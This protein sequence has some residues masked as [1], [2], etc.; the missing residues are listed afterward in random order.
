[1]ND[2]LRHIFDE[3]TSDDPE[4]RE[5]AILQIA[6]LLE[7]HSP[8]KDRPSFYQS[9]QNAEL[10][11]I[12][13]DASE[14]L[15]VIDMLHALILS[16]KTNSSMIWALGKVKS[17]TVLGYLVDLVCDHHQRLDDDAR[18]QALVAMNRFLS[19][20]EDDPIYPQAKS[21]VRNSDFRRALE[22][23]AVGG[24]RLKLLVHRIL[25][26]LMSRRS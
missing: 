23:I 13:L 26:R 17:P 1:M 6:M 14:Q 21:L 16:T 10:A 25:A 15:E 8:L 18:Q 11:T 19:V 2:A 20:G 22:E 4:V 5:D 12:E 9:I 7:R 24:Q 3:A